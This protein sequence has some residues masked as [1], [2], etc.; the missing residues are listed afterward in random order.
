[1]KIDR[2]NY[3]E[4]AAYIKQMR[5]E[6][7]EYVAF[8]NDDIAVEK[9]TLAF[10]Q[11]DDEALE[12][13]YESSTDLDQYG[14]M[15][16]RSVARVMASGMENPDLL[17]EKNGLIDVKAM[18]EAHYKR[19]EQEQI[20]TSNNE[21]KGEVMNQNQE[22]QLT[23]LL[24]VQEQVAGINVHDI[25][26]RIEGIVTGMQ[27]KSEMEYATIIEGVPVKATLN[28][29]KST[30]TDY[31]FFNNYQLEFKKGEETLKQTFYINRK[32]NIS[33]DEAFRIMNGRA[34]RKRLTNK[35]GQ[36]Y[37]VWH[38]NIKP[39]NAKGELTMKKYYDAYG[40]DH[41]ALLQH[42]GIKD[43]DKPQSLYELAGRLERGE[44]VLVNKELK[45][46]TVQRLV[47]ASPMYKNLN[48][49]STDGKL[50]LAECISMNKLEAIT[51]AQ[52]QAQQSAGQSTA[53]DGAPTMAQSSSGEQQNPV[54]ANGSAPA[55]VEGTDG[56][57][58]KGKA[59]SATVNQATAQTANQQQ[60]NTV[61]QGR[62]KAEAMKQD[63]QTATRS[64]R[65]NKRGRSVA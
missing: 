46:E 21:K 54:N 28:F 58:A 24:Y 61:S 1:M 26:N 19:L 37:N 42:S 7:F 27:D 62:G 60:Q 55:N 3:H 6:G 8:L 4:V 38:Q 15:A 45:G 56:D 9:E 14:F 65:S 32:Q 41:I 64:A 5:W 47:E 40:F 30:T 36:Q 10:F 35:E 29:S 44:R 11:S 12:Y 23:N 49:Y 50:K 2:E 16:T 52:E 53:P 51:K 18:V 57:P 17:I 39:K 31:Q 34:V 48:V 13:C 63:V 43:V 59:E 25:D 33:L 20:N 22:D